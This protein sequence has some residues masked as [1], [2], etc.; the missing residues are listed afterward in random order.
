MTQSAPSVNK[1]DDQLALV[2]SE[3]KWLVGQVDKYTDKYLDMFKQIHA[4]DTRHVKCP[5]CRAL[6]RGR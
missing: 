2:K 5:G 6:R 4:Q 3:D 1:V